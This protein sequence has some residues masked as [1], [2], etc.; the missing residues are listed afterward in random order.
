[1]STMILMNP[2]DA[3]SVWK[4]TRTII[5]QEE[6]AFWKTNLVVHMMSEHENRDDNQREKA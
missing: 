2:E 6:A 3:G 1:M 4:V 5:E